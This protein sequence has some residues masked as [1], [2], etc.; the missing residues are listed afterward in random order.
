MIQEYNGSKKNKS[1]ES[2]KIESAKIDRTHMCTVLEEESEADQYAPVKQS[3]SSI[4]P[5]PDVV[6]DTVK[7][8]Q[9]TNENKKLSIKVESHVVDSSSKFRKHSSCSSENL[10][11]LENSLR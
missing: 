5:M 10:E 1:Y 7:S 11:K 6:K 4:L 9:K 3:K 2:D 8:A